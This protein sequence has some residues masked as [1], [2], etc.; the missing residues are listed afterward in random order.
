[1][2]AR[3]MWDDERKVDKVDAKIKDTVEECEGI[4]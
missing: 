4:V 1:M 3:I 2:I